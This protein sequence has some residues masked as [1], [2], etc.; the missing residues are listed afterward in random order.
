MAFARRFL[1]ALIAAAVAFAPVGAAMADA[2][3][4]H[5]SAMTMASGGPH[6]AHATHTM[7]HKSD[8][9]A[10]AN[11]RVGA[12]NA[13]S[14]AHKCCPNQSQGTCAQTC[15]Q[16]CF[17]QLAVIAPDRLAQGYAPL[18]FAAP[19]LQRPRGWSFAPQPPPPRA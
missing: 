15:L 8:T 12:A 7:S 10:A 6:Q 18:R 1:A 16:K 13:G 17:G 2:H 14:G 4:Q 5:S 19:V 11:V 9:A 3:A